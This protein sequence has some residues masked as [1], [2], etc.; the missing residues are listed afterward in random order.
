LA[1]SD[2]LGRKILDVTQKNC[3]SQ[4]F[5]E[6][7]N[8]FRQNPL[9]LDTLDKLFCFSGHCFHACCHAFASQSTMLAATQPVRQFRNNRP[10]PGPPCPQGRTQCRCQERVLHEIIRAR[11][12]SDQASRKHSQPRGM[13]KKLIDR[14]GFVLRTHSTLRSIPAQRGFL[15]E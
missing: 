10:Q 8:E 11:F 12:V 3:R 6:L 14:V 13:T 15:S 7:E 1:A 4:W 9:N 2:L 5:L